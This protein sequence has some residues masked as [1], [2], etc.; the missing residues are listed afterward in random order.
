MSD[1]VYIKVREESHSRSTPHGKFQKITEKCWSIVTVIGSRFGNWE[2]NM[3]P[4]A[5]DLIS[6]DE[7]AKLIPGVDAQTLKRKARAGKLAVYRV[8]K[9]YS[10]TRA[11]L[12][13]MIAACRVM[14]KA[15]R[16]KIQ[17]PE[18][19]TAPVRASSIEHASAALDAAL[20]ALQASDKLKGEAHRKHG[21]RRA[22]PIDHFD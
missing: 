9:A 17:K 15:E 4:V 16:A 8:G 22:K 10:T 11:D 5:A 7:A 6:L 19:E 2:C 1:S 3:I 20:V 21:R 12:E 13:M 18:R 14:P